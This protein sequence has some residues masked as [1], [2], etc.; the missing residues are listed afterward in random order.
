MTAHYNAYFLAN[1]RMK[2]I[3]A[4]YWQSHKDNYNK[5]LRI[6]P[7]V[8]TITA[9]ALTE[10][11]EDC[12]KKAS[13][14]IQNHKNSKWVDD[15]YVLVGKARYYSADFVNAIE[16]FKY[17]N[18]KGENDNTRHEALVFLMRTFIDYNEESNA[19]A[20]S[21]Y[22]KKEKLNKENLKDLYLTRAYF[23]QQREDYSNMV[24]NLA[25]A[26]PLLDKEDKP[27]RIHFIIGQIFQN[28]GFE[29]LAYDNYKE[30]LTN[31]PAYELSFYTRLNMAQVFELADSKDVDKARKFF[32]NLLKD[33]KNKE[34]KDKIYYEMAEFERKQGN[35]E[36]AIQYYKD[37]VRASVNNDRQK[38]YAYLR[39]GQINYEEI[40]NFELAKA[41][42]D[43]TIAVMPLDEPNYAAVQKR[44][45]ILADFVLQLNTIAMQDSLLQLAEM[46]T[47]RL[48]A[49]AD[50]RFA[51]QQEA[52][53]SQERASQRAA[54]SDNRDNPFAQA[55]ENAPA[56]SWYFY[57]PASVS[58][59]SSEFTRKWGERPLQDNWR[60]LETLRNIQGEDVE[61]GSQELAEEA[62]EPIDEEGQKKIY[63]QEFL[64]Q[65]P[66]SPEAKAV[67]HK[68]I[69]DAYYR[70]GNIYNFNLE[71]Q[72][73][74]KDTF[75]KLL[76]Q[77]P[78]TAYEPEVLYL[79]YLISNSLAG[80]GE[81]F[82][83]QLLSEFPNSTYAKTIINP[84]YKQ[85]SEAIS[86]KLKEMYASAFKLYEQGNYHGADSILDVGIN[87]HEANTF[88]DN[89]S[90]LKALIIGKTDSISTY[91]LALEQFIVEFP[92]SDVLEYAQTLLE[93]SRNF[94][95]VQIEARSYKDNLDQ[96]HLFIVIYDKNAGLADFLSKQVD[97]LSENNF[98][99]LSLRS[100]KISLNDQKGMVMVNEFKNKN[101]AL[102]YLNLF[103]ATNGAK[104]EFSPD[105]VQEFVITKDNFQILYK[106]KDINSYV[107]FFEKHY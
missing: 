102:G 21:D 62:A 70:L 53:K 100:G 38:S 87:E 69:E 42:Y 54:F 98:K 96:E 57:S 3:E 1:E 86:A 52:L 40:K 56:G 68:K 55:D 82:K 60:R 94:E 25:L 101:E 61:E 92:D 24:K 106:T 44:Q 64:G 83:N 31:N 77:Y 49:L 84:N 9:S 33:R 104:N 6:F 75:L 90:L 4:A 39:L 71:E 14:A 45:E 11:L 65:I 23:Y 37:A 81:S 76:D 7:K 93:A 63:Q 50:E 20:V 12:I 15:S 35:Q 28:L 29:S 8:D 95:N 99:D 66:F 16:T 59:G 5:V 97:T 32:K 79:L 73:N 88:T 67:A 47:T 18:M 48:M 91:Q 72:Q 43:S 51:A 103:N 80:N 19:L 13:L 2:E 30:S 10:Q 107:S 36:L 41:Y 17:V 27:A 85:E 105:K 46:D 58:L 89:L 78:E 74:A 22:L 34:F 26:T